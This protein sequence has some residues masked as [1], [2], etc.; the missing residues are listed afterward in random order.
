MRF[1]FRFLTPNVERRTKRLAEGGVEFTEGILKGTRLIGFTI[2]ENEQGLFVNFPAYVHKR[3]DDK[4][5]PFNFLWEMQPGALER[6]EDYILD[7]YEKQSDNLPPV[8]KIVRTPS[9]VMVK[10]QR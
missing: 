2:N 5:V 6:L 4:L 3:A 9:T 7:E 1:I 8:T 10:A